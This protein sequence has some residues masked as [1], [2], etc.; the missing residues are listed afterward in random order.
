MINFGRDNCGDLANAERREWLVTNGVGGFASGTVAG[1]LTRRYHGLLQAA[2]HPPGDRSL[3]VSKLDETAN[4]AGQEYALYSNNWLGNMGDGGGYRLI[5]SFH[6]EGTTP[7]WTFALADALLEKRIW[8]ALGANTTYVQY[9]LRRATAPLTLTAK[10]LVNYRHYHSETRANGWQMQIEPVVNGLKVIAYDGAIPFHLLS[11]KGEAAACHDWY[12]RFF[13]A[14]EAGRG[15]TAVDDNLHAGTFTVTLE[16]GDSF[17]IVASI[18]ATPNLDGP[19][20]YAQRRAYEQ[21]LLEKASPLLPCP[22]A[23]LQQLIL[24]ADQF[25]VKRPLPGAPDG[26]SIIAGYPW[27]GDW[28]R[29][30]MIALSGLT[31]AT[32]RPEIAAKILRTFAFFVS[33]G[34]LPN[35]FPDAGERPEY[36]TVDATLWYFE[37][38]RAYHAAT[39]DDDFIRQLYPV[40]ADII[41]WHE[42]GTRYNIKVDPEDGLLYAGEAGVQ[43]TWM[44]AKVDDWV[45]TPRQGKPVE[46][47]A[48]WYNALC[49]M[50]DFARLLGEKGEKYEGM[51][52]K[53]R[54]GFGRFWHEARGY[55][56]DVLDTPTGDDPALRPNQLLAVSLP[57]SALTAGQQKAVV[58]VC[59]QRLLTSHGLRSLAADEPG[60]I[61]SYG[62]NSR[63]RD[64]AYHQGTVWS[65][66]I[67]PFAQAH[68]RVY[69]DAPLARSF[70]EP[71]LRDLTDHGL[72]SL[73]EI[74]DGDPPF[75]PRG[76]IAQAWAVAEVLRVWQVIG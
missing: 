60:Y 65:W 62:G 68:Y 7:V 32:G 40:L 72:G 5:E 8:M 48:L 33:Q 23:P 25:L 59:A 6:L 35:R 9:T 66:L 61:G 44:D 55:C 10:A 24:A 14:R 73:S 29:D 2:L 13:L 4:Y 17:T 45:V 75:T 27:F 28:G 22:S 49:I 51:A 67:G 47:N 26:R 76:C 18:D 71:L 54:E 58:D 53:A 63:Q 15:L 41:A 69:G 16:A 46:V 70:L 21:A 42:R 31:L 20:V 37:A 38:M 1:S 43:L 39:G 57:H 50:A 11:D 30:T 36:N 56:Y 19:A 34:M 3:L 64:G 52:G 74:F 12:Y